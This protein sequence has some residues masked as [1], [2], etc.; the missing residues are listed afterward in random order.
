MGHINLFIC[1]DALYFFKCGTNM[2]YVGD[3]TYLVALDRVKLRDLI[4]NHN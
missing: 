1:N 3:M 4:Q 2:Y